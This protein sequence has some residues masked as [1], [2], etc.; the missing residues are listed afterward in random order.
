MIKF[1]EELESSNSFVKKHKFFFNS[2]T[3]KELE[4]FKLVVHGK[5]SA[6][7]AKLLFIE[8]STVST[9]RKRIKQKL[10][11]RSTFD[12]YQYAKA[13]NIVKFYA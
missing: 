13:F 2:L 8:A 5:N 6:E 9:H 11:L 7:I 4:V 1:S 10:D 3:T 12:W